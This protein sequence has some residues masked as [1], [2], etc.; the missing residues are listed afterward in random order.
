LQPDQPHFRAQQPCAGACA[1]WAVTAHTRPTSATVFGIR[2]TA[3]SAAQLSQGESS[4][5]T[6]RCA[7][8]IGNGSGAGFRKGCDGGAL[9]AAQH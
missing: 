1:P 8:I 2:E 9:G 5:L 6:Q 4:S 7:N 3:F